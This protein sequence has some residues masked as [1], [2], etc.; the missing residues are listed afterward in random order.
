M[1]YIN[2]IKKISIIN[3]DDKHSDY[4]FQFKADKKYSYSLKTKKEKAIVY[5]ILLLKV[6]LTA[7]EISL[8]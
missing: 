5:N 3:S 2:T 7:V 8:I 6:K 4:F 1:A